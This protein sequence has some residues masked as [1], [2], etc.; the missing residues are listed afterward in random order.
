[1]IQGLF[2]YPLVSNRIQLSNFERFFLSS[3]MM[4]IH[5]FLQSHIQICGTSPS[6][7]E[8]EIAEISRLN[9]VCPRIRI[10]SFYSLDHRVHIRIRIFRC[11]WIRIFIRIQIPTVIQILRGIKADKKLDKDPALMNLAIL[12]IR[13]QKRN[14]TYY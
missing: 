13:I 12:L 8:R 6:L 11:W 2:F 4:R 10:I 7:Y 1:M 3:H 9:L 14:C 5:V